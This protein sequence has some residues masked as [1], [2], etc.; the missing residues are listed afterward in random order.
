MTWLNPWAWLGLGALV[1]P[2]VLHLLSRQQAR[3]QQFPS[4]RF[5]A[6]SRLSLARHRTLS[7]VPLLIVRVAIFA[8]AVAALAQP[9]F[10]APVQESGRARKVSRAIIVDTSISM[11]GATAVG[12]SAVGVARAEASRFAD[13]S[14]T[15]TMIAT[16]RPSSALP[17]ALAW[18]ETQPSPHEVIVLSD[19]QLGA[20]DAT[21]VSRIPEHVG[22]RTV[23]IDAAMPD[24]AIVMRTRDGV[25][26]VI[27]R[28]MTSHV[29]TTVEWTTTRTTDSAVSDPVATLA[30]LIGAADSA[31]A[32][33]LREVVG[34]P[35]TDTNVLGTESPRVQTPVRSIAIV[36]PSYAWR[37]PGTDS[38][39]ARETA[40]TASDTVG[41]APDTAGTAPGANAARDP[42]SIDRRRRAS[43]AAL[44]P[45]MLQTITLLRADATLRS[46]AYDIAPL[47]SAR[48]ITPA[49]R[50]GG[51]DARPERDDADVMLFRDNTGRSLL[52]A[53]A[54]SVDG[55]DRLLLHTRVDVSSVMS[56]ALLTATGR[57]ISDAV[58][59]SEYERN[60]VPPDSVARW[61]RAPVTTSARPILDASS[62][63]ASNSNDGRWLWLVVL[64]LLAGEWWVRQ[65]TAGAQLASSALRPFGSGE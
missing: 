41:T 64:L 8:A 60:R 14:T 59:M 11:R 56:A 42:A 55:H 17:G 23:S 4:L 63:D 5:I 26:T 47:V 62:D 52:V 13:S 28:T 36:Y 50:A 15:S 35:L 38:G 46:L 25:H 2:L 9:A 48:D 30:L 19:F 32:R 45:W 44:S 20:F 57:A 10:R 54:D 18:L 16:D 6:A 49:V 22:V 61:T 65:R 53:S 21:D 12:R 31:P 39:T 33:R 43:R 58:P 3:V 40:R 1:V 27:A 7:D 34:F 24:S 37:G 29:G 51:T